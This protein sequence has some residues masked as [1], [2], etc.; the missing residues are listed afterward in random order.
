MNRLTVMQLQKNTQ[1]SDLLTRVIE[2]HAKLTQSQFVR[3]EE[4][5]RSLESSVRKSTH[6]FLH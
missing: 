1:E 5:I 6:I 3:I 4:M 2:N